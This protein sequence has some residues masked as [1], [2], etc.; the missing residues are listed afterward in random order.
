MK[1]NGSYAARYF[2]EMQRMT[3]LL[4]DIYTPIQA[5]EWLVKKH[6]LLDG[7]SPSQ[8]IAQGRTEEVEHLIEQLRDGDQFT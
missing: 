8:L 3:S 6:T 5:V 1:S 4:Q 2:R 7:Q